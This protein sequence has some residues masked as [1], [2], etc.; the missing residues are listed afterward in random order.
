MRDD[1]SKMHPC[2]VPYDEL[3]ESEKKYDRMLSIQTLK[4]IT[5]MGFIITKR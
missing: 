3:P 5:Q 2:L 4:A 1:A